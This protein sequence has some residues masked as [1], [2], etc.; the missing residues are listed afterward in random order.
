MNYW[1]ILII[2]VLSLT[3]GG[4]TAHYWIDKPIVV[5]NTNTV[6]IDTGKVK[7]AE[8]KIVKVQKPVSISQLDSIY[9]KAKQWAIA[10]TPHDT[11]NKPV[12]GL[13][14]VSHDTSFVN[15][16]STVR[17]QAH[18]EVSSML[19]FYKPLFNDRYDI[20]SKPK[21]IITNNYNPSFW[22][23]FNWVLF[24]G[25]GYD[26]F[27]RTPNISIGLGIGVNFKQLF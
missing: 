5:T 1:L 25:V 23:R 19:P 7:P 2:A 12:F 4:L 3:I 8:L 13:F 16:D 15:A 21:T 20:T 17:L 22:D 24:G 6:F 9:N 27:R 18:N 11:V 14:T 10:N 26:I